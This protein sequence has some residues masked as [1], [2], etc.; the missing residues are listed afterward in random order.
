MTRTSRR[1]AGVVLLASL[2]LLA[3]CGPSGPGEAPA[4]PPE[5]D[6]SEME[7]R[8]ASSIGLARKLVLA[9]PE[10]PEAW[11]RLGMVLQAHALCAPAE[12][13]Y[14][15]AAGLAPRDYRWPYLEAHCLVDRLP[16]ESIPRFEEA[17]RLAPDRA[18][19]AVA[20][21]NALLA[22]GRNAAAAE[23][24]REALA[25]SPRDTHALYGLARVDVAAGR[26]EGARERLETAA[27]LAPMQGEVHEL[28][29]R[30]HDRLGNDEAARRSELRARRLGGVVTRGADPALDAMEALAVNSQSFIRRGRGLA[31]EGRFAE[32]EEQFREVLEIREP[33]TAGDLANLAATV[34]AQGRAEEAL[35]L[36]E[37][38]LAL[39]PEHA[40]AHNNLGLALVELGRLEEAE[41]R[42][43]RAVELD[44]ASADAWHNL[45]LVA[46]RR[47][48]HDEAARHQREALRHD[49]YRA[50]AELALGTALA[51]AGRPE[52][53][54]ESW[55]RALALDPGNP[56]ASHNLVIVLVSRGEHAEAVARLRAAVRRAPNSSRLLSL[57]AW[58]LATAP[59]PGL[60]DG[61]EAEAIARRIHAAYPQDP[62]TAD[63]LAAALAER[64]RFAEAIPL[65]R[66]AIAGAGADPER[67]A[68]LAARLELYRRG[69]PYRQPR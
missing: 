64:G 58:E 55:R 25:L 21:G 68:E 63:L 11:G 9:S 26:L 14:R 41:E 43:R 44:P 1:P 53:A 60:R 23:R 30:V 12:A 54:A 17:A 19:V 3:G 5:V 50:D 10:D 69:L 46:A 48:R 57:L 59:D 56:E 33:T 29:A 38:A 52:E 45:G 39:D 31:E 42:F 61:A 28:L 35:G 36:Y 47:G 66:Q 32:A 13:A 15:R 34:A 2:A 67:R 7:A 27:R 16:A 8:V 62:A 4:A 37:R 49:P 24:F 22:L 40:G 18:E 65:V 6:V 20:H 51:S